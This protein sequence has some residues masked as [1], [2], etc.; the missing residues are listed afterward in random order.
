MA[1]L[2]AWIERLEGDASLDAPARL[3]ERIDALE[4][5]ERHYGPDDAAAAGGRVHAL[6]ARLD[7]ANR[8]LYQAIREDIRR[9]CGRDA[10]LPWRAAEASAVDAADG[11]IGEGYDA[12]DELVAGVLRFDAPAEAAAPMPGMVG[13]QPTPAR[14]AFD[15][16]ARLGL[17]RDDVLV[18]LGSGLGHVPLL[19]AICTPACSVGIE[20]EP[21][22]V[23]CARRSAGGLGLDNVAF[24]QQDVRGADLSD[25]TVFYLYTPFTGAILRAVLDTLRGH[26]ARRAIRICSF[27][28]C[29]PVVAGESW[30]QVAGPLQEDRIAVF[31]PR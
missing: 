10:L 8:A 26:A 2:E 31:H 1:A 3:R 13:Y 23:A 21:A 4:R 6:R 25:A 27:G 30:L 11:P 17:D 20:I 15:L 22:Y 18:D 14:H 16:L 19:A 24:R 29:T 5:I 28:P 7:A 12:L 9:G